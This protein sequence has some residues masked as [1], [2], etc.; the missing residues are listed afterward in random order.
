MCYQYN[1]RVQ[2]RTCT[3]GGLND[4][5]HFLFDHPLQGTTYFIY[6]HDDRLS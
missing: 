4:S 2:K 3:I 1:A 6:I 5:I